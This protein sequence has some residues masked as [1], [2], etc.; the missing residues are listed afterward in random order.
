MPNF[1][2]SMTLKQQ[3]VTMVLFPAGHYFFV[4]SSVLRW[5]YCVISEVCRALL[6]VF[7]SCICLSVS[8]TVFVSVGLC[9]CLSVSVC[10]CLCNCSQW[11][12]ALILSIR[13]YIYIEGGGEMFVVE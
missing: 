7:V 10:L 3:D 13:A 9:L 1:S 11:S 4:D 8:V 2:G 6:N 12:T 5:L